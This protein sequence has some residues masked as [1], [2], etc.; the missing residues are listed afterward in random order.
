MTRG[1]LCFIDCED[2]ALQTLEFNG[3]MYPSGN[4]DEFV[5]KFTSGGLTEKSSFL[6]FVERFNSRHYGYEQ[7]LIR[8]ISMNDSQLDIKNN[9]ADYL[10]IINESDSEKII[11]T[12]NDS[13]TAPVGSLTIIH[14]QKLDSVIMKEVSEPVHGT[15]CV[16]PESDF[17]EILD[18]LRESNDLV[19]EV[20]KLFR[21]SRENIKNDFL[22]GASL[23][24][25]HEGIVLDLL[26]LLMHDEMNDIDYFVY[27]L[28]YGRKYKPGMV[29]EN[30]GT[31]IDLSSSEKLYKYLGG[32][33]GFNRAKSAFV[34][35]DISIV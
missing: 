25:S 27:E 32:E 23:Q 28:D 34:S 8:V 22:N 7:D 19:G 5:E 11:V 12:K 35:F 17:V 15:E 14:F 2:H 18:T 26:K 10:Y 33:N 9:W 1:H 4:A 30:D 29:N 6:K 13:I 21:K 3:D 20:N 31:E 24:I 16:L